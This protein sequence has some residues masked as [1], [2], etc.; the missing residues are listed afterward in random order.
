MAAS[1]ETDSAPALVQEAVVPAEPVTTPAPVKE[2]ADLAGSATTAITSNEAAPVVEKPVEPV[3]VAD[4]SDEK[5]VR[6]ASPKPVPTPDADENSAEKKSPESP[7]QVPDSGKQNKT[8]AATSPGNV[9]GGD[10]TTS[11]S[12]SG[13][14][15]KLKYEY[16]EGL[17]FLKFDLLGLHLSVVA[18]PVF[19]CQYLIFLPTFVS[20]MF[21]LPVMV[22]HSEQFLNVCDI[23]LYFLVLL[24]SHNVLLP[25]LAS[26]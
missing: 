14:M 17:L 4:A 6:P 15:I 23:S 26:W 10:S 19:S 9:S 12:K 3:P 22:A 11:S 7:I 8:D 20:Y 21:L 5:E 25:L 16:K 2:A 24:S 13:S 18:E 1:D